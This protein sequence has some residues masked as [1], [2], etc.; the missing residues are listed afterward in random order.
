MKRQPSEW[1]EIFFNKL[2]NRGLISKLY[3]QLIQ[4]NI[5]NK[6]NNTIKNQAEHLK[7]HFSKENT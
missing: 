1:K 6:P 7:S 3:K 2:T 5:K 4:L